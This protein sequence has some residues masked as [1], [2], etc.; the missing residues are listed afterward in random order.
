[1]ELD[2]GLKAEVLAAVDLPER[3]LADVEALWARLAERVLARSRAAGGTLVVGL[4]GPQG[5]GKSTAA[6]ALAALLRANGASVA[7]LSIDDLY[8]GRAARRDLAARVHP[9]F[10]TRGPPGT[11]DVALALRVLDALARPS[12]V[13]LPRFDKATDDPV[14][15]ADWPVA[16]GP[17]D[18]VLF[19][20]WC[21]GARP[22]PAAR[23]AR[24]VNALERD[25]DAD[26]VWRTYANDAL[27]GDYQTLFGRT[28]L[29]IQLGAPSFEAV[30]GWRREQEH[31]LIARTG[32]GMSDAELARFVQ[33]YERLTRWI[34]EEMPARA[35]VVV[36][37]DGRRQMVEVT[38]L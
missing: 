3:F 2:A 24:P 12:P 34:D 4:N 20:G 33:H 28:D 29:L 32:R 22:Q 15:E 23:L 30:L 19:E 31:R 36:R 38:G 10:A 35:D 7:V 21:V 17:V 9:L 11:H 5:S 27:A 8:L 25:E 26:G 16:Q 6:A 37:L 18:V 1:M 14:P 13:A